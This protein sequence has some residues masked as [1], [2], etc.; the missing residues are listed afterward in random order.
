[1]EDFET[2]FCCSKFP[3]AREGLAE[4]TGD[5]DCRLQHC[6]EHRSSSVVKLR[7]RGCR[8]ICMV[9]LLIVSLDGSVQVSKDQ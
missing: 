6:R 9:H 4:S 7:I 1:M 3:W 2:V 5:M 8:H